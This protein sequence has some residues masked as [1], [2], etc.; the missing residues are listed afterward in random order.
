MPIHCVPTPTQQRHALGYPE[1]YFVSFSHSSIS[2]FLLVSP[3]RS[4]PHTGNG[5]KPTNFLSLVLFTSGLPVTSAPSALSI[6]FRLAASRFDMSAGVL[7]K[8][9]IGSPVSMLCS[10]CRSASGV[11]IW[12]FR[13]RAMLLLSLFQLLSSVTCFAQV[14]GTG[15]E[16]KN[17]NVA[18]NAFRI[19][20]LNSRNSV[21]STRKASTMRSPP[22]RA[23]MLLHL[24]ISVAR[25]WWCWAIMLKS[26]RSWMRWSRSAMIEVG[27]SCKAFQRAMFN[28]LLLQMIVSGRE[29][30]FVDWCSL[31]IRG[32]AD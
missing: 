10:G 15:E 4:C 18:R 19:S 28:A 22:L 6:V 30:F 2:F 3:H 24:D 16:K 9:G 23:G 12:L 20:A 11:L 21:V 26:G 13:M 14:K 31:S 32:H 1:Q 17:T 29:G 8:L 27:F 7:G 5:R 25:S